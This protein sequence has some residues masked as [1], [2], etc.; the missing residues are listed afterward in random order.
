M[1]RSVSYRTIKEVNVGEFAQI[2]GGAGHQKAAG[3]YFPEGFHKQLIELLYE[4][5]ILK[6]EN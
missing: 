5:I 4:G 2:Y 3:S 1:A 6:D